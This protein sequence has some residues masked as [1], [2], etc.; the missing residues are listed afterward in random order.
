MGKLISGRVKKTPQTGITSDRYEYLGLDQAEP[1]LGDPLIGPSSIGAKPVPPGQQY[2]L[3][4]T[5]IAGDRYWIPNQG[6]I[7][8]GSISIYNENTSGPAPLGLVGGLSSTTQLIFIGN[9]VSAEGFL[10][11]NGFPA[12]NVNVTIS[13]PGNNGSVLFKESNDFATS[14][15]LVFNSSVGILTI[16]K[17]LNVGS[18]GTILSVSSIGIGIKTTNAT[19]ELDVNGD[20]RLRGTIYDF[21]NQPG[22]NQQLLIKNSF[23]GLTWIN[24]SSISAGAGGTITNIQYHN[25][26]GIVGGA[27]NFVFDDINNRIG[28]GSTQPRVTLDVL[29]ISSFIGGVNIDN[30]NVS[31]V[32]TFAGITTVT[33]PTLFTKQL[34]VS[35]LSTFAGITTV[36]GTTLFAKQLNVSGVTTSTTFIGALTGNVTGNVTGNIN[37][38]GVSTFTG[39]INANGDLDVDGN[40]ELDNVNISEN[41]YVVGLSTLNGTTRING[42][43]RVFGDTTLSNTSIT[44][45]T[46][47]QATVTGLSTFAGITTVTGVTLFTRQLSVSGVSTFG[48]ITTVT[49]ST[50]FTKQLSVSGVSTVSGNI[51]AANDETYDIGTDFKKFN[52]VYAKQFFGQIIG[53]SETATSVIG[54]I[55]NVTALFVAGISTFNGNIRTNS[56]DTYDIGSSTNRFN[57]VY[58]NAFRG[59]SGIITNFNS[60]NGNI[61][62]LSSNYAEVVTLNATNLSSNGGNFD[63]LSSLSIVSQ[64][65]NVSGIS[66]F[67]DIIPSVNN[68]YNL[69][70][71]SNRWSTIYATTFNGNLTGN[72]DT[73]TKLQTARNFSITGDVDAPVVSFDGTGNVNLV[74]TLDSTGV[75]ANTYG[76]STTVP[77]FT[78]DSKGRITSVTNT[79]VNFSTATVAQSDTVKTVTTSTNISFFPTFV[80]SNNST[81]DFESLFT[82]ADI[83]YN[84]ST[85]LLT[86]TNLTVTGTSTFNGNV[87]LGNEITDT[88]TFTSRIN[89]SV[90]PSTNATLDF[91]GV[92]NR[93]STIYATTFNGNAD[94]ATKLQTARNF[95]ITGD[96]DA[97]VVS[98]D[99]TGNVNLVTTLDSTGVVANTYGSSTTVPVFTVDAKGRITSVTNT[100]VNFS[101]ATVSQSDTVKTVSSSATVL[102]PTFVDSD[103]NPA[104]YEAL[105]TDAGISYNAST[106]LLTTSNLAVTGTSTFNGNVTLGDATTATVTFTARVNSSVLPSTNGTLDFGGVSNRWSTIYAN[107]FV[108]SITG[109]ADSATKLLNARNFSITGDVDAPVVSFDG[110]GNVNLVTTLDSTGVVANTYGS[111][112]TVPVFTVDSKGRITSVTNTSVNFSTA[113]VSQSDTIKTVTSSATTL[114]PTFVDTDNAIAAYESVYTDA[115][116]SYNASTNLL[117]LG[118]ITVTGT[119]TFNGN[120]TLGD[121]TTDTVTFTARVNSS[122]L[123]SINASTA[124]DVNGKDLGGTSNYWRKIYAREFDGQFI[125]N[126]DTVT[127]LLN[128]RNI[129]ITGDLAWNV[130]F[131]G[132]ANVTSVGTLANSGVTANT[133]GSSTTV[134]VFTVDAKGRITS[135]TNTSVNFSTATVL[136]ADKL[137]TSRNIA[138]TGDL[139]WNVNFD[140]STNVTSTGTLANSGVV[141]NTYGSSTTVPVF[142]VD[143]KGRITSV[144]NTSVNFST[145]TV[146]N[147]DKLTTSRN[148]AI[149]GDLAWSVNFDGSANVTSVGT[150]ANSGVVANTYGS[151]TTVPVFT[152]DAKGRITSVTNTSVNFTAATVLSANKLTT[153]RNIAITGDLSWNVNFD[154]SGNVTNT[155]TLAN[156]GVTANTYGSSS[157]VPVFTVDSKGRITSVTNT[158][159]TGINA[160][161]VSAAGANTQV[162]FNDN[163]FFAGN[164]NFT[165]NKTTNVLS[166][167]TLSGNVTGCTFSDDAVNK[168]DIT[169]RTDSG[170]YQH[171]TPTI[172]EG[173]P[174]DTSWMHMIACT[175]S[176]DGN[177]YS[178]QIAA[179]FFNQTGLYYRSVNNNGATGW[180]KIWNSSNDGSGSG[181]DADLLD[182]LQLHTG[183]NNEANKVV[184]TDGNGYIQAGWINTISGNLGVATRLDRVYSSNDQYIRYLGLTDFKNQMG[185]SSKNNYSRA[186]D[187]TS[188]SNYWVGSFGHSGYGANETF[189]G[190]SGFFDIWSGTNYP[191]GLSHIH[192]IN[193]LHYTTNSLGTTGGNAYG[194]QMAAQYN[195]DS[196]PWW[197]RCSGGSFSSWL[198]LVSYGN[199][200]S[201][202]IYAEIYYD[203]NNTGYYLDPASTSNL[204]QINLQGVLRRNTSAAGYL[205]GNYPTGVDGNSSAAIYTI[206]GS[207]QPGG[208]NLGNMYGCGYTVGNGTANPGLGA[209]GWGFYVASA[210]TSRIFLDSDNGY[211]IA[212]NSW[213]AQLFYDSNNTGYYLDP[214]STSNLNSVSMQGGNVYGS[215]YFTSN[216]GTTSGALSSPPLQAYSTGNNSAFMSFHK[217]GIYAVNFGLDSDN[218]LRIGGWS[219]SANRWQLDMSGNMTVAGEVIANSDIKLK[220]NIEVIPNALEKVYQ[221]RGVTF[222]RNDQEDKEKRH[223]GV[224]AQEVEKV[225]PEVVMEGN[226]GIKSVAYGNL[227]GLLIEAI[228]ELK[229]EIEELKSKIPA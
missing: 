205:E 111:S 220:E 218:V 140:G 63:T 159:I 212:S 147:A 156:S 116:I 28:I 105:Y 202:G 214:A 4:S 97:P 216:L 119:S 8:P 152:V 99:G 113:T 154:G 206:G 164:S 211:G 13:P 72:A 3:V 1:N 155:G 142:A 117:T 40:T 59:T 71:V 151:S 177:Y 7:I 106:N 49:G 107:S 199:N 38:P 11:N 122:V 78:V 144:T 5:G 193:M 179:G 184:R 16:G 129:A 196:G 98:F 172:A 108:G 10:T 100:S 74:T 85:N 136:N 183:T 90:L 44:N 17:G 153:A 70:G 182:G 171:D 95:S 46:S 132:N 50:L 131:D 115:G 225:L 150:L 168:A 215:M 157:T 227:V 35:G 89:S 128:A 73:A 24:Q 124:V 123:P 15:D 23:G 62:S 18:G 66:T 138:I 42:T 118:N 67:R 31:G 112:T 175:H 58:A 161:S 180:S 19:Q 167:P 33:G 190:G 145:A 32:S 163:G 178:M 37:A 61:S 191:S 26:V 186:V 210:G 25:S 169:T 141:A 166:V 21:N 68:T 226:D 64:R 125:G 36:T 48:G 104:A 139:S 47:Q 198:R 176:N 77:V 96:V 127:K 83:F 135:V 130:N 93:W 133:Y 80:N 224:I 27:S 143:A 189:H 2:I 213:R 165:F 121:A 41:L 30:L 134:P 195:S 158:G 170:F 209:T 197:R 82:D 9:A 45:L 173:W 149:T 53:N 56:N 126:A 29:G 137:T 57:N 207:Y 79:S 88:V 20:L 185:L 174:L 14:S 114:Y 34:N 204:N 65:L 200:Q 162:Q 94:T 222:T 87:T 92:S 52:A 188:D 203:S 43:V 69:G 148:I 109:N 217:S 84:P 181:L 160:A 39:T 229:G 110:T 120:V 60:T 12:P 86:A 75:V 91:G 201:G 55:A 219:A 194:W 192:G 101:T 51:F 103:N 221:I 54:G 228:K 146:L 223:A 81:A 208:T 6:G 102:Y 187:Y 76:S 22:T